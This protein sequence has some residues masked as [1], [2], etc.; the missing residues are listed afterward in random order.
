MKEG[1][2]A[3][4][5]LI[6]V[7]HRYSYLLLG[8]Y[9]WLADCEPRAEGL[10]ISLHT[11]R[12]NMKKNYL[13]RAIPFL[14]SLALL[15]PT[16]L[17]NARVSRA[18]Q[19]DQSEVVSTRGPAFNTDDSARFGGK[20]ISPELESMAAQSAASDE[21]IRTIVQVKDPQSQSLK[22]LLKRHGIRVRKTLTRLQMLDAELPA[23]ALRELA[24]S[25]EVQF[26]SADQQVSA[27]GHV[28]LT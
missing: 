11:G 21:P 23:S 27:L 12:R 25:D 22:Q 2:P 20:K 18:D 8:R 19:A 16:M 3:P 9:F 15:M 13:S 4:F 14:I 7:N 1:A 17:G 10:S 26:I 6:C 5:P 24:E 28:K